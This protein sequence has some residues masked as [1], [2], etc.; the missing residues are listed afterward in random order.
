MIRRDL[1]ELV[2]GQR[3]EPICAHVRGDMEGD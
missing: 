2:S 3:S 1:E